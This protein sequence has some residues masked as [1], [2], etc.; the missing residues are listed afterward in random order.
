MRP[1]EALARNLDEVLEII[2][3]YPV[4]N[5]RVFGSVAR[6]EDALPAYET[7]PRAEPLSAISQLA[8]A[9]AGSLRSS[10]SGATSQ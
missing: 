7:T 9:L 5:P 1:S 6:G 3:R 4:T 10:K 2:A 8:K